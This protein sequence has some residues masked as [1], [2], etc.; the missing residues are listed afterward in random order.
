MVNLVI[1]GHI[2]ATWY[3]VG[4]IWFVQL[5]HYP[6]MDRAADF[7]EYERVHCQKTTRAVGP[8]MLIEIAT[9]VVWGIL[10]PELLVDPLYIGLASLL[11][12]IW[13]STAC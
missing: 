2:A 9:L 3:M 4:L 7:I 1:S 10:Q 11:G 6:M 13:V 8:A 5:V 12:I